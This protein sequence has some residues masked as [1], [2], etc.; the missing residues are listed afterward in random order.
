MLTS[1]DSEAV[2][3]LMNIAV[4][5]SVSVAE[6]YTDVLIGVA[7]GTVSIDEVKHILGGKE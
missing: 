5:N 7:T 1:F 4:G 3:S 2:Y 6:T